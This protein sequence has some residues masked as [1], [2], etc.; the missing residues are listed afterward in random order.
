MKKIFKLLE[1]DPFYFQGGKKRRKSPFE[2]YME[3]V[4]Q[5]VILFGILFLISVVLRL[6]FQNIA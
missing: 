5:F 4:Q 1:I 2:L 6:I 3:R